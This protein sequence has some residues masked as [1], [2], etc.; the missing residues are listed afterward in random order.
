MIGLR[1]LQ[2]VV[3]TFF[4]VIRQ[5]AVL[6]FIRPDL[7]VRIHNHALRVNIK[8]DQTEIL[9]EERLEELNCPGP[10]RQSVK[11]FHDDVGAV[12]RDVE[13]EALVDQI[14]QTLAGIALVFPHNRNAVVGFQV[15]PEQPPFQRHSKGGKARHDPHEGLL[16]QNRLH[17][18]V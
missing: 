10:V 5:E 11:A 7:T 4:I 15:V 18:L 13:E 1:L 3:V 2:T 8:S 17:R 9:I 12:I 14:G 6:I 16:Q